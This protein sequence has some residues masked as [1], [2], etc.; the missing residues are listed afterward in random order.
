MTVQEL[1]RPQRRLMDTFAA[2]PDWKNAQLAH[3]LGV[4]ESYVDQ[5]LRGVFAVYRVRT[6]TGAVVAHLRRHG[7]R[8]RVDVATMEM[9]L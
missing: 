1:S 3:E 2:N 5:L 8:S 6:R 9:G 7:R 4:S